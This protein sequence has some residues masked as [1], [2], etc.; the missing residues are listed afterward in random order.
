MRALG[1]FPK[2]ILKEFLPKS[3]EI[4]LE[5]NPY[6]TPLEINGLLVNFPMESLRNSFQYQWKFVWRE[7]L[8]KITRNWSAELLVNFPM[9][10]LRDAF[11]YQWKLVW[12]AL[13]KFPN[14]IIE[15]FI[16]ISMGICMERIFME[17]NSKSIEIGLE[18]TWSICQ[19]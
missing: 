14:G 18:S 10:S 1:Q 4:C 17:F 15:E 2:R 7:S 9:E 3:T 8:C 16:S 6:G 19:S 5:R 11:Q 13:G 12:R